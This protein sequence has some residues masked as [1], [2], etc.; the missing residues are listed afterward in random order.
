MKFMVKSAKK[1]TPDGTAISFFVNAR[2]GVALEM[3]LEEIY[4]GRYFTKYS[5]PFRHSRRVTDFRRS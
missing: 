1:R 3:S 2:S 5:L 4:I